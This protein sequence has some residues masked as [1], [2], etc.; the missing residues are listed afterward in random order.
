MKTNYKNKLILASMFMLSITN[1]ITAQVPSFSQIGPKTSY[2]NVIKR[3]NGN[4]IASSTADIYE[5]VSV[6]GQFQGLNFTSQIGTQRGIAQLLGENSTNS[7]FMATADNGIFKYQNNT[8][9]YN[10]LT[11]FGTSGQYW[12]KL[13]N[14][15]IV[16][17]KSG[18]GRNIYYSDNDGST[19]SRSNSGDVDWNFITLSNSN[20][21]FA[22]SPGGGA[23]TKGII[24]STN[25]GN[26]WSNINSSVPLT[27]AR[28]ISKDITGDL[29]VIADEF[30]IKKSTND[31]ASWVQFSTI[32]NG[33]IGVNIL[34]TQNQIY[35][36]T[37]NTTGSVTNFYYTNKS[38]LLW[39]NITSEFPTNTYFNEL[40]YIDNKVF[41][42]TS[43]GLFYFDTN[44]SAYSDTCNAVSGSLTQ[45]LV[46]YYPFCG[47]A[48]DD[49]GKGN[50]G[51]VNGATLTTDRFG[52]S[53]SAYSFN[54]TSNY[55]TVP[56][57]SGLSNFT[58]ITI[59]GWV[60]ISQFPSSSISNGL[61][62]LVT[63]WYGSG[64][65]G[66]VTD[67][68]ACYLRSN[69]QLVG[70]TNQYRAYPNMLQTPSNLTNSNWY[71]FVMVHNSS[72]GGSF[73]ING[74]LVS[75]YA[76][77]GS[78]CSSTNPLY[79]GCDNGLGTLN[80]FLNGKLDDI[81]IWNRALTTQEVTQL[82]NQNQ[83]FTNTTVTETLVINVGQLSY[84]N[85][86]A[87]ANNI[88]IYPNPASTQVNIAFNNISNLN[89][90][91][92]KIIN[93]LGQQVATTPIKTTGTTTTMT[94][95][96]WGG[97]GLYFVQIVNTQ[98][99]IVDIKKILLQ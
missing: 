23:A 42:C 69:N 92:I 58:D 75:T 15:R 76:T 55:I 79:L 88:T 40:K 30:N 68:Y 26:S 87:Y 59:S 77:T 1:F 54:G 62:G 90:G 66:G 25:N 19:W 8:W 14:G 27:T 89:G 85:P 45:G 2:I 60:N 94:L 70:G 6:N 65:C 53:N 32:P 10:A 63:K 74:V 51:T 21:L 86:I 82:Y 28:C 12:T 4:F 84:T 71:H 91:S 83:C 9:S 37:T 44:A 56:N 36:I 98:G 57:S 41:A 3:N 43:N 16:I 13:S 52:N 64:S 11:G 46:A 50:N 67:N 95:S 49:S 7:I 39:Q 80:R 61:A 34:F 33:E 35:L 96:T 38:N 81:G 20:N 48:N 18:G 73:Y 22:V 72:T 99:Q 93:S 31:G 47:N 24:R 29:Y 97:S 78:L 5:F 17:A